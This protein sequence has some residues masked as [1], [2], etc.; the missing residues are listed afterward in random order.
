MRVRD[1]WHC[2]DWNGGTST[3]ATA[4]GRKTLEGPPGAGVSVC[5]GTEGERD[6]GRCWILHLSASPT[7]ACPTAGVCDRRGPHAAPSRRRPSVLRL[8]VPP[9]IISICVLPLFLFTA[10][11]YCPVS[12]VDPTPREVLDWPYTAGGEGEGGIP[13]GPSPPFE[14]P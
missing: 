9:L 2:T 10:A 4:P 8:P 11:G 13:P 6:A 14:L 5:L 1:A 3:K 7:P 12:F